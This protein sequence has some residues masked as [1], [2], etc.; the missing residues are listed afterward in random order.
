MQDDREH[1]L[2]TGTSV[3]TNFIFIL[4]ITIGMLE[5][6]LISW[7]QQ[8][9]NVEITLNTEYKDL[10]SSHVYGIY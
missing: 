9:G 8:R 5:N 6:Y 7:M 4:I 1:S 2:S 10:G 3:C